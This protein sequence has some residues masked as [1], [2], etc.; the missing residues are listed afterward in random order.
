MMS[1][2]NEGGKERKYSYEIERDMR[3]EIEKNHPV[4]TK[5]EVGKK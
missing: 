5:R 2:L 3:E 1:P 4:S